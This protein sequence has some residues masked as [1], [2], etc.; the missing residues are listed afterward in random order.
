MGPCPM[1]LVVPMAVRAAVTAAT[2]TFKR[3]SQTLFFMIQI[4]FR[5]NILREL[6]ELRELR[7]LRK[8]KEL[9]TIVFSLDI[10]VW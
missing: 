6:K 10:P 2:I 1:Q 8:L 5:L 4:F 3:I 9:K 7:K